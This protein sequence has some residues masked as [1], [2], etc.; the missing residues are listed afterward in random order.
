MNPHYNIAQAQ[1]TSDKSD[2]FFSQ[3]V[4]PFNESDIFSVNL[5]SYGFISRH[6]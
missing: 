5:V 2:H 4:Y 3:S 1:S 6:S